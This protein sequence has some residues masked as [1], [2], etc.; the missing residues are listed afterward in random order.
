MNTSN[1]AIAWRRERAIGLS[2]LLR[3]VV[4]LCRRR[5]IVSRCFR[6]RGFARGV[7]ARHRARRE[8]QSLA[9]VRKTRRIVGHQT[10]IKG[11][12]LL[13][14]KRDQSSSLLV[15]WVG[16][17]PSQIF[18]FFLSINSYSQ[19]RN[20]KIINSSA[21]SPLSWHTSS[22]QSSSNP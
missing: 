10:F 21:S 2:L 1:T 14:S 7:D 3:R 16:N 19:S 11:M 22:Y 20:P 8:E 4:V 5:L 12:T 6:A 13:S 17:Y 9:S 15:D 18:S